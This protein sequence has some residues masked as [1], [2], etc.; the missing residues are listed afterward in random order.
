MFKLIANTVPVLTET[1]N[2]FSLI[3]LVLDA[4]IVVQAVLVILILASLWSWSVIFEK[5][6]TLGRARKAARKFEEKLWVGDTDDLDRKP[7]QGLNFAA[8][9]IFS[10]SS[11][12][13]SAAANITHL[14]QIAPLI[15]RAER[16]MRVNIDR[17]VDK[18]SVNIGVLASIG[19][20]SPFI[21]LFGTVWGI[22]YAFINIAASQDTSLAVVAGPIAEALFATGL[23]LIA[24]I[25]AT[26]FY[27]KFAGDIGRFADQ[28]DTFSQDVLIRLEHRANQNLTT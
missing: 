19:S 12:E 8:Y 7:G 20:A 25:P 4:H 15:S 13:W 14:S 6:F 3:S 9:R 10:A 2:D 28:L 26:I 1:A 23:G 5:Q 18:A 11:K 21:G 27:N 16:A 24:A 17:E 22:M